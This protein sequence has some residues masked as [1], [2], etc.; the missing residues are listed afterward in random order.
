MPLAYFKIVRRRTDQFSRERVLDIVTF[1]DSSLDSVREAWAKASVLRDSGPARKIVA[2]ARVPLSG[3]WDSVPV[4]Y[5]SGLRR[6][7]VDT[8]TP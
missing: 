8:R 2:G 5:D 7:Y 1:D 4:T 3:P 6:P